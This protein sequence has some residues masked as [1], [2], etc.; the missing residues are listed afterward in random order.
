MLRTEA[1]HEVLYILLFN[2]MTFFKVEY[3]FFQSLRKTRVWLKKEFTGQVAVRY[4]SVAVIAI[5][6]FF[7]NLPTKDGLVD[8]SKSQVSSP[9][10]VLSQTAVI[11][12]VPQPIRTGPADSLPVF[13]GRAALVIDATSSAVLFEKNSQEKLPP[14]SLTKLMT[15]LIILENKPLDQVVTISDSCTKVN[16]L[17]AG[18]LPGQKFTIDQ[19]LKA[20]LLPS[21]ADAACALAESVETGESSPSARFV[22]KMNQRAQALGLAQTNFTNQAGLDGPNGDH[23]ST[24]ADLLVLVDWDLKHE[25]FKEIVGQTAAKIISLDGTQVLNLKNTNELLGRD[26]SFKGIKTGYTEKAL[27]C[28]V[29]LYEKDGHQI[30][31]VILGSPDRF[32]DAQNLVKWVFETYKWE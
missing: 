11:A 20:L 22:E 29:F 24:A 28:L 27:G 21:A 6:I 8:S 25:K 3:K 13:L 26:F 9:G 7:N 17:K 19:V 1:Q 14:A 18:F 32:L 15:A 4:L 23:Y 10:A 2:I 5:N 31:G 16:G 12:R 30:L